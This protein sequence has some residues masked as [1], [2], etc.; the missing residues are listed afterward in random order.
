M[1]DITGKHTLITD[2]KGKASLDLSSA[3]DGSYTCTYDFNGDLNY[4]T[5]TNSKAFS[6][7]TGLETRIL[8]NNDDLTSISGKYYDN[9]LLKLVLQYKKDGEWVNK[10]S[11]SL[12]VKVTETSDIYT[13]DNTNNTINL[14]KYNV[15]VYNVVITYAGTTGY[16]PCT[17]T[18]VYTQ[19]KNDVNISNIN[20]LTVYGDYNVYLTPKIYTV[21]GNVVP[22]VIMGMLKQSVNYTSISNNDGVCNFN[23]AL[24]YIQNVDFTDNCSADKTADYTSTLVFDTDHYILA[25]TEA[26]TIK[27]CTTL[28]NKRLDLTVSTGDEGSVIITTS[29]GDVKVN[30]TDTSLSVECYYPFVTVNRNSKSIVSVELHNNVLKVFNDNTLICSLKLNGTYS[31]YKLNGELLLYNITVSSIP[32]TDNLASETVTFS[33]TNNSNLNDKSISN[34]ITLN[35]FKTFDL[36]Y[37]IDTYD[38]NRLLNINSSISIP[39]TNLTAYGLVYKDLQGQV[40]NKPNINVYNL[41]DYYASDYSLSTVD[42]VMFYAKQENTAMLLIKPNEAVNIEDWNILDKADYTGLNI[43]LE[44]DNSSIIIGGSYNLTAS[45]GVKNKVLNLYENNTL[46]D[47]GTT[48]SDGSVVFNYTKTGSGSFNYIVKSDAD[49]VYPSAS[50]NKV[51]ITVSKKTASLSLVS[52]ASSVTINGT[53]VLDCLLGVSGKTLNFYKGSTL[54][55]TSVTSSVGIASYTVTASTYGDGSYKAVL[56][57]DSEYYTSESNVVVVSVNK[58]STSLTASVSK[59]SVNLNEDFTVSATISP[60]IAGVTIEFSDV[61]NAYDII[62][63][64]T[65]D[66]NGVATITHSEYYNNTGQYEA[67]FYGTDMYSSSSAKVYKPTIITDT[68]IDTSVSVTSGSN[69]YSGWSVKGTLLDENNEGVVGVQ[70]NGTISSGSTVLG[71]YPSIVDANG[72]FS[73]IVS[74]ITDSQYYDVDL[75]LNVS[76]DGYNDY[77]A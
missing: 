41:N 17:K 43:V 50:S 39:I 35:E 47:T 20:D 37:K 1:V 61:D 53:F 52:R 73:F 6:I 69:Y 57:E 48:G 76:F 5:C 13:V 46:I 55:G 11:Y 59:S 71:V 22:N 4:D 33:L 54:L 34:V 12:N 40:V 3:D 15:G 21:S 26:V 29:I 60:A 63:S 67:D 56:N 23:G 62:G 77:N 16:L 49:G 27:S 44:T 2:S 75:N 45:V 64:A 32:T 36:T 30:I 65:T 14:S 58:I 28:V 74:N 25:S 9:T 70:V 24:N 8:V 42:N 19:S 68:S 18:V 51:N 7:I 66:S 10:Q 72:E 31:S 38:T